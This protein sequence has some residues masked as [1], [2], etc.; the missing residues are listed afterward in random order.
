MPL[1][2]VAEKAV[3]LMHRAR[4]GFYADTTPESMRAAMQASATS[5]AGAGDPAG[6]AASRR[7]PRRRFCCRFVKSRSRSQPLRG[8]RAG[9]RVRPNYLGRFRAVSVQPFW[10]CR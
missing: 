6:P 3:A 9:Y 8:S 7:R 10:S 1:D 5:G 4:L 2:P